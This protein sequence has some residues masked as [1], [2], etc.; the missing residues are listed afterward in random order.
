MGKYSFNPTS[1]ITNILMHYSRSAGDWGLR[2][3]RARAAECVRRLEAAGRRAPPGGR[4]YPLRP[5]RAGAGPHR[6][7]VRIITL[8]LLSGVPGS[9]PVPARPQ[10]GRTTKHHL[11]FEAAREVSSGQETRQRHTDTRLQAEVYNSPRFDKGE[12][13][14]C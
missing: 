4:H 6:L 7:V 5:A 9:G 8:C 14:N 11:V 3:P 1:I 13:Q 2:F 10:T 12:K